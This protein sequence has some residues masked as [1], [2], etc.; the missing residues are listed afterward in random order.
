MNLKTYHEKRDFHKTPEPKGKV[1]HT[2][3]NLFIIQKHAASHL[4]YDFR[5]ELDGVL[6]SW[7]VP[8]GPCLDPTVKRLAM[9]VEDHPVEY[10]SFE[11]IIP[12]GEYGGGTVMLWD[13]GKWRSLDDDPV[14]AY[15]KGHL[16]FELN[17][18][19]LKGRWD[20][21][22]SYK[23]KKVWFLI[24]YKDKEAKPLAEYN[25]T[26]EKPNSVLTGQNLEEITE[27]YT[28]SWDKQG[29]KKAPKIKKS[30]IAKQLASALSEN[31]AKSIFP[32]TISPELATLVDEIPEGSDWLHEIK[33]DGYR[34]IAF[35]DGSTI[36]L[37]SRN[38]KDWTSN[39]PNIVAEL[40]KLP[41]KRAIFDGEIVV[42]DEQHKSNFQL[43]QNS[44]KANKKI[45]FIYYIFDL[46]YAE[47]SDLREQP[48][49]KRKTMLAK[50]LESS[51]K[52]VLRFSEHIIDQGEEVLKQSCALALEGIVSKKVNSTYLEKRTE[53]W[54]KVKCI[55]RQEFV[56]GGYTLPKGARHYFGS[57]LVGF[58]DKQG[59]LHYCGNVGTGFTQ[60][61]LKSVFKELE[62]NRTTKNPFNSRPPDASKA[63][64]VNPI[65]VAEVEFTE[66]TNDERLRHPSFQGLRYD[67]DARF[68]SK[69]VETPIKKVRQATI[70]AE[71]RSKKK[72]TSAGL[73]HA[74]KVIYSEDK[75][76]KGELYSYYD[77]ISE[78]I[79]PYIKNRLLTLVRCPEKYSKCF[80]QKHLYAN[81]SPSLYSLAVQGKTEVEQ[82][83]YLKDKKGLLNLIQMGV[84]EIHPWGSQIKSLEYPDTITIDLDPAPDVLWQEVVQAAFE[85]KKYLEQI[86]LTCFVKTTGG[87]GLHVVVPIL[88]E[89]D[90]EDVKQFTEIFVQFLEKLKPEA[91]VSK[92]SKTKRKGKIFIDYLR[93]QRSATA[94]SAYST[95]ARLHAP[96]ATPLDWDEL[97]DNFNDTFYTIRTLPKRLQEL[98]TDPWQ[99]V[100][101]IKQ[102]L[103]LDVLRS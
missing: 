30:D 1:Q 78:Y 32:D 85:I 38:N 12:E 7:A 22:K 13:K 63:L 75:I 33:L 79:L 51:N 8:K 43:L 46:I 83:L 94:I 64:W 92:M 5:L 58:Y 91:Y 72:Q 15:E 103:N 100:R 48:L 44:V 11:G 45:P 10:G 41:V 31:K 82:Y 28:H 90:W 87:K 49:L 70:S 34:I 4:H 69:E 27:N 39:F 42:L 73:T 24:K 47:K 6:K 86:Q 99:E 37:M 80:Y 21:I 62:K 19:K 20:L 50:V 23:D 77:E 68:V 60:A 16:R 53:D 98:K 101:K 89:Y 95:R 55:K 66:W 74:D 35:K 54:V 18:E 40:K 25:I 9:Q 61:S 56:I 81:N 76:T 65:L 71:K 26:E 2:H 29:L 14:A 52:E 88:P 36:R 59:Q 96:V 57:L 93:N 102:S 97:T 67:K 17:A 3:K 84:L